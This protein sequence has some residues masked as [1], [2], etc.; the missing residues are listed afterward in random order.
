MRPGSVGIDRLHVRGLKRG[1]NRDHATIKCPY[2][3]GEARQ[4][5]TGEFKVSLNRNNDSS[6]IEAQFTKRDDTNILT[7]QSLNYLFDG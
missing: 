2:P 1:F 3:F 7:S 5:F 4:F 6:C